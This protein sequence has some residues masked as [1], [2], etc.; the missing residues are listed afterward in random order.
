MHN[1]VGVRK[2]ERFKYFVDVDADVVVGELGRQSLGLHEGHVLV[3]EA[4]CVR[5]LF[6]DEVAHLDDVRPAVQHLQDFYFSVY[7]FFFDGFQ[8][9]NDCFLVAGLAVAEEDLGVLAATQLVVALVVPDVAPVQHHC[10]VVRVVL[11][12]EDINRSIFSAPLLIR[13]G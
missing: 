8:H 3:D 10:A 2:L 6:F 5:S 12:A 7:L 11:R 13:T 9:L 1:A 4:R